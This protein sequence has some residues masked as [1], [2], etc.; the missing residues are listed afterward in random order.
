[1]EKITRRAFLGTS[2]AATVAATT[3]AASVPHSSP[4]AAAARAYEAAS[5]DYVATRSRYDEIYDVLKE[6]GAFKDWTSPT[7]IWGTHSHVTF[8]SAFDA[9]RFSKRIAFVEDQMKLGFARQSHVDHMRQVQADALAY[10][11]ERRAEKDAAGIYAAEDALEEAQDRMFDTHDELMAAPCE[12]IED[13]RL[14]VRC[15]LNGPTDYFR[16]L[17]G[18]GDLRALLGSMV[19]AI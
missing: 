16:D 6:Q 1:M 10:F 18:D 9:E 19:R 14:K 5:E 15:I 3:V 7:G 11:A 2:A 17:E 4:V 8:S 12:T 13:V